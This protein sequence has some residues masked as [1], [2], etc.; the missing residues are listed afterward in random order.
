[1]EE[2]CIR[3][4]DALSIYKVLHCLSEPYKKSL[5]PPGTRRS[6]L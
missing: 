5:H 6:K 1:V 2:I 3:K 4:D